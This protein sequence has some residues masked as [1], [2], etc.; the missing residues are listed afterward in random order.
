MIWCIRRLPWLIAALLV[1]SVLIFKISGIAGRSSPQSTISDSNLSLK[2]SGKGTDVWSSLPAKL[3]K[4]LED[5]RKTYASS[6]V[7]PARIRIQGELDQLWAKSPAID[8]WLHEAKDPDAPS[9]YRIYFSKLLRNAAKQAEGEA[10]VGR[11]VTGLREVIL[12]HREHAET[13][14]H[15]GAALIDIDESEETI[16]AIASLFDEAS[17]EI[18]QVA[19]SVLSRTTH[20]DAKEALLEFAQEQVANMDQRPRALGSAILPLCYASDI[21]IEP[22]LVEITSHSASSG[23]AAR[24]RSKAFVRRIG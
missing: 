5:L 15:I 14:A 17:D 3:A 18:A 6:G 13:R 2:R 23:F 4:Q 8:L 19:V 21:A 12:S 22:I 1:I 11:I 9:A 24:A 16:K 10:Q 20:P 7:S